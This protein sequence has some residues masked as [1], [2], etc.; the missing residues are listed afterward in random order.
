MRD[1][2]VYLGKRRP[3]DAQGAAAFWPFQPGRVVARPL[4]SRLAHQRWGMVCSPRG[5]LHPPRPAHGSLG[6]MPHPPRPAHDS[7]G[8]A[9]P[10]K[11]GSWLARA[12]LTHQGRLMAH[13]TGLGLVIW[14]RVHVVTSHRGLCTLLPCA[15]VRCGRATRTCGGGAPQCTCGDTPERARARCSHAQVLACAPL[16]D[17][18]ASCHAD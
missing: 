8:H 18:H 9:S 1:G 17:I 10:T 12:C 3:F 13:P 6:H 2:H 7:L 5:M 4:G 11:A 15:S 14:A 16:L